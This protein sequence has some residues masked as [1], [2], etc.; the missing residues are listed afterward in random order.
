MNKSKKFAESN[1]DICVGCGA[2]RKKCPQGAIVIF[3]GC[4]AVIN[5]NY[6][7]GCGKCTKACPADC[8]TLRERGEEHEKAL[9]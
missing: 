6:C 1:R 2:C 8:I 4:F 5:P 7:I 3:K 9:V